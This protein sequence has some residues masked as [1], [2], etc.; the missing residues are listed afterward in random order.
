MT[1]RRVPTDFVV[2]ERITP[3]FRAAL[4][5]EGEAAHAVFE[6]SK[7]SLT[8]PEAIN[9]AARSLRVPPG[10]VSYAG[11]KDK[12][13]A[14][15]QW[16]SVPR[17]AF[18]GAP[19]PP[20][21]SDRGWSAKFIGCSDRELTAEAIE[22]N[23]FAIVVRDLSRHESNEMG[24]R[25]KL[26]KRE[27][28]S[29]VVMNYFGAQRFGSARHGGGFAGAMLVRGDFEGAL[30]LLIGTPARKDVGKTRAF[31]RLAVAHWGNWKKLLAELPRCAE[32]GAIEVLARGGEFVDAFAALPYFT[33]QMCVEAYQSHLW[34]E[35]ARR[36]AARIVGSAERDLLRTPDEFG[37]MLFPAAGRVRAEWMSVVMP[38]LGKNSELREPW[39][40]AAAEVL[41]GEGFTTSD[42]RI[43]GLK[44]PYFGEAD[45]PL[46]VNAAGFE[47]TQGERDEM[48]GTG[49]AKDR[50]KRV[51][52]FDLPRGAYATVVLRALGQ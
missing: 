51:A 25:A 33:Q 29:L 40:A 11:L 19:P 31:T 16:V 39:A 1:I 4:R 10:Q 41:K 30:K 9:Y 3:E 2:E 50:M 17:A 15:V 47:M 37:E 27:D 23:R 49:G 8:T 32:L 52:K 24:R 44:R 45:R 42:L 34:N 28:G 36:L 46:F 43:R 38:V 48:A 13:A 14:T 7:T 21:A 18:K 5:T 26:L 20:D 22:G 35:T 6:L 12:H